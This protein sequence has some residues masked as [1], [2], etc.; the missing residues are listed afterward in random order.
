MRTTVDIDD[1]LLERA[2]RLALKE[3]QTL[4]AVV[5]QALAAYLSSRKAADQDPPFQLLVRGKAGARFPTAE[6]IAQVE[7]DE[8]REALAIPKL[9]RRATP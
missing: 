3:K 1:G 5:S 2:K 9:K 6:E 4:G 8:D 7:E